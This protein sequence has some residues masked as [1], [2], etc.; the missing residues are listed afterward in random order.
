[1]NN[2]IDIIDLLDLDNEFGIKLRDWRNQEFV[3]EKMF[4]KEIIT[5]DEHIK[6]LNKLAIVREKKIFICFL[7]E[8]PFGVLQYDIAD[9]T[10]IE[11]GYNLIDI[12]KVNSGLGA[13]LEY[14]ML[15]YGFYKLNRQN[16]FCR[17]LT[18]NRKVVELH[19]KFGF[20]SKVENLIFNEENIEICYQDIYESDWKNIENKFKKTINV[21]IPL[22]NIKWICKDNN[23]F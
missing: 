18:S 2:K 9:A 21:L 4:N 8:E 15:N 17:T 23:D 22:D 7:N 5:L 6:F 1:M 10:S 3:R 12:N 20:K 14:E 11:F 16:I 19:K 13:I